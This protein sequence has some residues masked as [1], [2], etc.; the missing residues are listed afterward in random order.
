ME[1]C[2]GPTL[3]PPRT[4][5]IKYIKLITKRTETL[6][7]KIDGLYYRDWTE[8][9]CTSGKTVSDWFLLPGQSFS[10]TAAKFPDISLHISSPCLSLF[11]HL[12]LISYLTD[13]DR[14]AQPSYLPD[15]QDILRVRVP[16]TGIIEYPFD[17]ENVIFR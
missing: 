4:T 15:L 8:D 10:L 13:L 3:A 11:S 14:I 1:S 12:F 16:T 2:G 6:F 17:M 9:F 5:L 7:L